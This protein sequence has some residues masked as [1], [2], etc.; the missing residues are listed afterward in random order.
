M[1]DSQQNDS[2]FWGF[3]IDGAIILAAF[4][5][6]SKT[7]E[8]MTAL[9]PATLFGQKGLAILYGF[10]VAALIEGVTL[11]LHFLKR[12]DGN[13]RAEGYKWFLFGISTF[14]QFLDESLVKNTA[15]QTETEAFFAW[16]AL[17]I[18]PAIFFGLLWVKGG[19]RSGSGR[20][21]SAKKG[22]I[23]AFKEVLYGTENT[24]FSPRVVHANSKDIEK[25][26][27]GKNGKNHEQEA[28]ANPK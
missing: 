7:Q 8:V 23:P 13:T 11:A 17:G 4:A 22:I 21:V 18:V 26:K 9:A 2:A 20:A 5:L 15:N 12:F 1:N 27:V 14:C 6:Y 25:V 10:G 28:E 3:V 24:E 16:I 19:S